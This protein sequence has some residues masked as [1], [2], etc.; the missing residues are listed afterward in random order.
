MNST[1]GN[2]NSQ[3]AYNVKSDASSRQR[4]SQIKE[5][6]KTQNGNQ[7]KRLSQT[8]PIVGGGE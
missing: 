6:E 7:D 3:L 8:G 5:I 4:T 1:H 2:D